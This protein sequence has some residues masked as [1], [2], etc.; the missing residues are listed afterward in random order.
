LSHELAPDLFATDPT[1]IA[2]TGEIAEIIAEANTAFT[3]NMNIFSELEF[4]LVKFILSQV[5]T[6]TNSIQK[7]F[8]Q[9]KAN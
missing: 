4:N 5:R 8:V 2:P 1:F 7:Q 3:L 6:I 9:F